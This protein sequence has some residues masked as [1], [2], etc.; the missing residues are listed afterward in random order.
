[1]SGI[2]DGGGVMLFALCTYRIVRLCGGLRRQRQHP[3]HLEPVHLSLR[4]AEVFYFEN[5]LK[6]YLLISLSFSLHLLPTQVGSLAKKLKV[7]E[8]LGNNP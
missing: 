4:G 3:Q 7:V 2:K 1:L 6:H 5:Q 8:L